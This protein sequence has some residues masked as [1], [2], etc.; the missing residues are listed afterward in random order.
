IA[1]RLFAAFARPA[2]SAFHRPARIPRTAIVRRAI[3]K[4]HDDVGTERAL[5]FHHF[6]GPKEKQ[7]TVKMRT[8]LHAV[9]LHFADSGE[10]ENLKT[11]TVREDGEGPIH[12][13]V[14]ASRSA[15]DLEAR[16]YA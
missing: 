14:Q 8:E 15:K 3:V 4:D 11:A 12:K 6:F 7:R 1:T 5:D 10:T 9:R 13:A 2:D 16:A